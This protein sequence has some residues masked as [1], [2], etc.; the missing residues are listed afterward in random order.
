[1]GSNDQAGDEYAGEELQRISKKREKKLELACD[2][3]IRRKNKKASRTQSLERV[4]R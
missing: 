2:A 1:M 3:I 4:V